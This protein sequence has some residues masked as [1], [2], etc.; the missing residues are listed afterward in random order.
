MPDYAERMA[1]IPF[2][3]IRK[4]FEEV[5]RLK[6]QGHPTIPFH[7]GRPD[8]DTPEHIKQAAKDALDHGLT[9]YTS[10][11]GL[12]ELRQALARK[13]ASENNMSVDPDTQII[14]T[15]GA[16]EAVLMIMMG[17]LNPGDEVLIP[18]PMWLHYFYCAQLAGARVVS[19]PVRAENAFQLDPDDVRKRISPRTKMLII[20]SP[21]NPTG[22]VYPEQTLR[23]IASIVQEHDLLLVSDEIYE[24]ILFDGAVHISPGSF[25]E[26]ADRTI[27]VNGFSKSYAMTGWRLG[28]VVASPAHIDILVRVHQYTTV[29]A[30]SFAQAG[31]V[32][33]LN[34]PQESIQTM[35]DAFAARRRVLIDAFQDMPGAALSPTQGA[36]YAFPS[37]QLPGMDSNRFAEALLKETGVA[38]VAGASFGQAGEGHVRIAY[39]CSLPDV[40]AGLAALRAFL[41]RHMP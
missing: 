22:A 7:I 5:T 6:Q 9:A 21:H 37:I 17:M 30:T 23:E 11:Y 3:D 39:S 19:I 40:E 12:P 18:E 32:A 34:G 16:N 31:A 38:L 1:D 15:V 27:T 2:S 36:F 20:N 41:I 24:K 26:I 28:Y 14:V 29:C 33:A 13:L 10:N 25:P 35:L 4:I 8:F